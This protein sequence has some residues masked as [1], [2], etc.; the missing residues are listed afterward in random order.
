MESTLRPLRDKEVEERLQ[1]GWVMVVTGKGRGKPEI[2]DVP[3]DFEKYEE[4]SRWCEQQFGGIG[5]NWDAYGF[6]TFLFKD[7]KDA[8][9]FKLSWG[10]AN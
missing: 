9:L 2:D 10:M 8:V 5:E 1:Q 4:V 6:F 3:N 7:P